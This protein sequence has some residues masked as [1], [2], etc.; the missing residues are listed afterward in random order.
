MRLKRSTLTQ[1]HKNKISVAHSRSWR[2]RCGDENTPDDLTATSIVYVLCSRCNQLVERTIGRVL[3][4][5][6]HYCSVCSHLGM[7]GKSHSEQ[8]KEHMRKPKLTTENMHKPWSEERKANLRIAFNRP[9]YKELLRTSIKRLNKIT[10]FEK[11][12]VV[13]LIR[14]NLKPI[15]QQYVRLH[16]SLHAF[17]IID[18]ALENKIAIYADGKWHTYKERADRDLRVDSELRS[19]GWTVLRF[20]NEQITR[21]LDVCVEAIIASIESQ[22]CSQQQII[23]LT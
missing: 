1:E 17:T 4:D 7:L 20:T 23:G 11:Q 13:E 21:D 14:N 22:L 2:K 3:R 16:Y 5:E 8:A 15:Q 12:L 10:R 19:I 18:I 6:Q 9:E